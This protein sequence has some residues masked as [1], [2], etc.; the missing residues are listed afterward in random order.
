[1]SIFAPIARNP[2]FK[3]G[4]AAAVKPKRHKTRETSVAFPTLFCIMPS[5]THKI[6]GHRIERFKKGE[7]M[8][9]R[10]ERD[11]IGKVHLP[12]NAVYGIHSLRAA[13]NFSISGRHVDLRLI[14]AIATVKKAAAM[15]YLDLHLME[16][17]KAGAIIEGCNVILQGGADQAFFTD[18]LQ[19][20]AGTSTNMNVN[21][22]VAN[23]ALQYLGKEP[24][25]Y[26]T[27]SPLD[28]VNRGQSTNDVY[29]TALRIASIREARKLSE[30]CA[31]LHHSLRKKAAEFSDILKLGRTELMDALPIT[32]GQE[33]AAYAR[34]IARDRTRIGQAEEKLRRINL[35]GTAVG[36]G[37]NANRR[38]AYKVVDALRDLTGIGLIR[39]EDAMDLTQN[40]DVFA[41]VSGQLKTL[42]VNL[43][44]IAGDLRLMNS[45]PLGGLGEISLPPLQAGSSIMPG[46]VNPVI[47]EMTVQAA[48]KVMGN[49]QAITTA[50]ACGNLELNAFLPLVA[51]CLLENFRLL[52]GT[53]TALTEKCVD[54]L[55][56]NREACR[57]HLDRSLVLATALAPHIGYADADAI[58]QEAGRNPQHI[59]DIVL[60]RQLLDGKTLDR[61]LDYR[62]EMTFLE[63]T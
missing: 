53:V 1:M 22:V 54:H 18:A 19:G 43:M 60:G 62:N 20:G 57:R 15:A 2:R 48:L 23:L 14:R 11:K 26:G 55:T 8:E 42:A 52:T 33:F 56:A 34:A 58:A 30:A 39:A 40:N 3:P 9:Q 49:D 38:Y 25:D 24:G 61:I 41:E 51:D 5:E 44:K 35:G 27:V 16:E 6:E 17:T 7:S 21:E 31:R 13:N 28:D 10:E 47:P 59:R 4:I 50:A 36:T 46:K 32:L 63:E 37:S 12:K 45:G 29:P